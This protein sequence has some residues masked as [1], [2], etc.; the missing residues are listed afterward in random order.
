M[1]T[2]LL[3]EMERLTLV[4]VVVVVQQ[5]TALVDQVVQEY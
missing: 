4:A 1:L 2:V 3:L 5:Q